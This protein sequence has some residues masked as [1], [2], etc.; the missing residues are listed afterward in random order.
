VKSSSGS[1]RRVRGCNSI[2]VKAHAILAIRPPIIKSAGE[3]AFLK[4]FHPLSCSQEG[5]RLTSLRLLRVWITLGENGGT[6]ASAGQNYGLAGGRH[7]QPEKAKG[8]LDDDGI[9]RGFDR[10]GTD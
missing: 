4:L 1:N 10:Y 5:D 6:G 7:F 9:R 8:F 2:G 3:P